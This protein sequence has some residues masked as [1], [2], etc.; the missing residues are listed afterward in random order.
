[1]N[2]QRDVGEN[3]DPDGRANPQFRKARRMKIQSVVLENFR[4][5]KDRIEIPV[6]ELTAFIGKNDVGKS[7]ILDALDI[8]FEESK[9]EPADACT[10]GDA[11]DVRIGVV[12][13]DLPTELTLD[14]GARST[15]AA[16]HLLNE[17][18]NLEIHKVY[19]LVPQKPSAPEV[20]AVA[21][22]P[23]GDAAELLQ[24]TNAELKEMLKDKG[25]EANCNQNENPSMRQAIYQDVGDLALVQQEVPLN[26]ENGKAVWTALE[27]YLPVFALFKSDRPS[28][29]QDPEVQN[30]MKVAIRKALAEIQEQLDDIT[31]MIEK[32]AQETANRTLEQLQAAYPD[33]ARSL[34]PKFRKPSWANIFK[35][36]LESDDGI[37][38]NKR[39][40][41][42]RRLVLLS[43]FQAEAAQLRKERLADGEEGIGVIYAIEEPETSQH[44]DNQERIMDAL[45][46]LA[47]AGDQV[48]ITTHVPGLA[49]L[50]PVES[51]RYVDID[52]DTENVR[53]RAGTPEVF[54]EI[55]EALGVLPDAIDKP[56]ARVA[57]LMEGKTDIDALVSFEQVLS[58]AGE[59]EP[60]DHSKI[61]WAMGGG[62]SLKDWVERRYLDNLNISQICIFDSDRTSVNLP[63]MRE[64][65]DR[66]D[67]INARAGCVAFMTQKR[68]IENYV[69]VDAIGRLT[70]GR[71]TL[72]AVADI[73]YVDVPDTFA[74]EL[75][76]A[77]A[78]GGWVFQ[79]DDHDGKAIP[80]R[81][82]NSKKIITAYIMRHMTV[83][84]IKARSSYVDGTTGEARYEVLDWLG[85]IAQHT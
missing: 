35:L 79:P 27:K 67:E 72:A 36:D 76:A 85:E 70:G 74:N 15:L 6:S 49:G 23:S 77:I 68:E 84:E 4:R 13:R 71:V 12:F 25:L 63:A 44:P 58:N 42:V 2:V 38:L 41:G 18:G 11:K 45:Q 30:P 22:H 16:E 62:Q 51:L 80:P 31:R 20:F 83:D 24:K 1:M 46:E 17:A 65:Q 57:V 37:A 29:D 56:G 53:V 47:A 64:K 5:Y 8:F 59:I 28:S 19:N 55:A 81:K 33:L 7:S 75:S 52:P 3:G 54:A 21:V 69:H 43:F 40:S 73:D 9:P 32:H 48:L 50:L 61:F 60:L 34:T 66:C 10:T 82:R 14:R 26:K 78:A 39:G